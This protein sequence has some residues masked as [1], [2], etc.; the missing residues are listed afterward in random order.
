MGF[1]RGLLVL[2]GAAVWM[3]ACGADS[4]SGPGPGALEGPL[5]VVEADVL[6]LDRVHLGHTVDGRVERDRAVLVRDGRIER[7]GAASSLTAPAGATVIDAEGAWLTPGLIDMHV[8]INSA[9]AEAYVRSGITTVR[10]MWG[11]ST[12]GALIDRIDR[13]EVTGPRVATLSP[14]L[15]A[16]PVY[17]PETHLL[18]DPA[19]ADSVAAAM[20][21]RGYTELKIYQDLSLDVYDA[22]V[23]AAARHGMTLAGHKPSRVPIEHVIRSGQRS[24]EHLGGLVGHSGASLQEL[25]DLSIEHGTWH[26]PTLAVQLALQ[27]D[28]PARAARR[29]LVRALYQGGA[30]LL[31]GT[32]SGIDATQ[33][34]VSLAGEMEL[35]AEA[36]VPMDRILRM[37]TIEAAEYLGLDG[38]RGRLDPGFRADLTL[39]GSNPLEGPGRVADVRAVM[40]GRRWITGAQR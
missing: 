30:R 40:I 8:H 10:N 12:L 32:D 22:L 6:L 19:E 14:G 1:R 34:G 31:I 21:G 3:A 35:F 26:S 13:G 39:F 27:G 2:V 25:I 18:T 38:D 29:D 36:G 28:T 5:T 20:A 24:I 23:D 16:P 4:I 33:P 37:A 11:Y 15:D 7:V 17:W 9:D